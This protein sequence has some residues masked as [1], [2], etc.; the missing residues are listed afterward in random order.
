MPLPAPAVGLVQ[1]ISVPLIQQRGPRAYLNA[2]VAKVTGGYFLIALSSD[3]S[4][5]AAN[6]GLLRRAGQI[7]LVLTPASGRKAVLSFAK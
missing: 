4:D 2:A 5:V 1:D 7:S 3:R 6:L